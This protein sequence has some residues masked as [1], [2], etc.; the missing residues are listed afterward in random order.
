MIKELV[1]VVLSLI[2]GFIVSFIAIPVII[3]ISRYKGL[4]DKPDEK[5]KIHKKSIPNL[6]G[7]GV[8]C[9]F[10]VSC[11]IAINNYIPEYFTVM[12]ASLIILFFIGIK[13]DILVI[14]WKKK[15]AG[16]IIAAG[17][18]VFIGGVY[19]PGLDGL[20]SINS[21][22]HYTGMLFSVF[23]IIIITNAFNLIDGVDG[24]AGTL[25]VIACSVFG[26]WFLI[27][28]HFSEAIILFSLTGTLAAFL[29][30]NFEPA[31]IF[32]GDTGALMIGFI[33]SVSAFRLMQLNNNTEHVS[34]AS[35]AIFT[36][37]VMII[38]LLDTLRVII[39]RIVRGRS[40]LKPDSNHVHHFLIE[41]G[42]RHRDIVILLTSFSL[43]I[44]FLS[45]VINSW[46]PHLYISVVM[47]TGLAIFPAAG[48]IMLILKSHRVKKSTN[49]T[50]DPKN[51]PEFLLWAENPDSGNGNGNHLKR[52]ETA[53]KESVETDYD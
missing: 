39:I 19:I 47:L 36:F 1:F 52:K 4:T 21:F 32:L 45:V 27:G 37:S 14:D 51:A 26:V 41:K 44:T 40:P 31:K 49:F 35:P 23:T 22:P 3:R 7:V 2:I 15:L 20:F 8:F 25:S 30:F 46:E 43:L 13:D 12:T 50:F 29:F 18:I 10:A 38:P 17:L 24:L 48:G 11:G 33:L 16:Q 6:G 28:G 5:R 9:G 42:F 34:L 53:S